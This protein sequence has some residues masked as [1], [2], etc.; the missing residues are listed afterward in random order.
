MFFITGSAITKMFVQ[1]QAMTDRAPR[2]ISQGA[3]NIDLCMRVGSDLRTRVSILKLTNSMQSHRATPSSL[4][5]KKKIIMV[6]LPT[7]HFK[8]KGIMAGTALPVK[9]QKGSL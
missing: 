4:I 9:L 2:I 8:A 1:I 3:H 7:S 6:I 5:T